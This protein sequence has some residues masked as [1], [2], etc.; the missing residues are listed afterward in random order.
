MV[1]AVEIPVIGNGDIWSGEEA[2]AMQQQTG[3]AGIMV[4]RGAMGNPWLFAEIKAAL[5]GTDYQPHS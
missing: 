3:C 5:T 2:L 1:R 4:A